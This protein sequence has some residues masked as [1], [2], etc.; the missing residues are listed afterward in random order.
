MKSQWPGWLPYPISWLRALVVVNSFISLLQTTFSNRI[1]NSDS[2]NF[3]VVLIAMC[4][5][6]H[7]PIVAYYHHVFMLI[8]HWLKTWCPSWLIRYTNLHQRLVQ[9]IRSRWPGL[10]SWREGL[11]ALIVLL[12]AVLITV[13]IN[14]P[15]YRQPLGLEELRSYRI[16]ITTIYVIVA[17]YLYQYDFWVRQRRATHKAVQG[18]KS[19]KA[20]QPP[21]AIDPI[22][23]E[24][25]QLRIQMGVHQ[26]KGKKN[27]P[28]GL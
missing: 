27:K 25:E 19:N 2:S 18:N 17:A 26:V 20:K 12:V 22:E 7:L 10:A 21:V 11:N 14:I 6:I 16:Q 3:F 5:L 28:R 9:P 1:E 4:W 15:F 23:A 24:L 8:L 13:I